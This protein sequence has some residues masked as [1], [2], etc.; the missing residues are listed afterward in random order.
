M[1]DF[2]AKLSDVWTTMG[3][4]A[5]K[6]P[7]GTLGEAGLPVGG[8]PFVG[9]A[10]MSAAGW[11]WHTQQGSSFLEENGRIIMT[12]PAAGGGYRQLTTPLHPMTE[13]ISI[14]MM[15]SP[16]WYGTN[17]A[18]G[19][20]LREPIS[21]RTLSLEV[22]NSG[23]ASISM[24]LMVRRWTNQSYGANLGSSTYAVALSGNIFYFR[25][26]FT[27]GLLRFT[28]QYS[29]DGL[30]WYDHYAEDLATFLGVVPLSFGFVTEV[31]GADN[32]VI[33]FG[34]RETRYT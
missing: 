31:L 16:A 20:I 32:K 8:W 26:L 11:T 24:S 34:W 15:L 28:L 12:H 18:N 19:V 21:G 25:Y 17:R 7:E 9:C 13:S 1:T 30:L 29:F 22:Q 4:F 10:P 2:K 6:G 14:A 33:Y 23:G 3:A 5:P 27:R